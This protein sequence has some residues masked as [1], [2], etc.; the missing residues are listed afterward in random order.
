[1]NEREYVTPEDVK[2]LARPTMAHR[3]VLTTE[4]NVENVDP[5][6]IVGDALDSVEVPGVAPDAGGEAEQQDS[7]AG[8]EGDAQG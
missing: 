6:E 7:M 4:A 3:L 2:Q 5:R 8:Q 1:M